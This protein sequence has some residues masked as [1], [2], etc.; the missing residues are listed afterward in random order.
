MI[1]VARRIT[2]QTVT[3]MIQT[4]V[5][6]QTSSS[7]DSDSSEEQL[8]QGLSQASI[9]QN[10]ADESDVE[11]EEDDGE[12]N[13]PEVTA[14]SVQQDRDALND[15]LSELKIDRADDADE[16]CSIWQDVPGQLYAIPSAQTEDF[17]LMLRWCSIRGI[18]AVGATAHRRA[19]KARS[20]AGVGGIPF[21]VYQQSRTARNILFERTDRCLRER[22]NPDLD[23]LSSPM[24]TPHPVAL[25]GCFKKMCNLSCKKQQ[26]RPT[27]PMRGCP[28]AWAIP[29][30]HR[31]RPYLL[32]HGRR[33]GRIENLA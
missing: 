23:G 24:V 33:Y 31:R 20:A 19:K 18:A 5:T 14:E 21:A 28:C 8:S 6:I 17:L 15:A 4:R 30:A 11:V 29:Q 3:A 13:Q 26:G 22:R 12:A 10:S 32:P 9:Q 7:D 2:I 16:D 27:R 1:H 25:W